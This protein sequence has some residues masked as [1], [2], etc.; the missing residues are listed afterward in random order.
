[1]NETLS[2]IF[3]VNRFDGFH[4]FG[5]DRERTIGSEQG[6]LALGSSLK[7]KKKLTSFLLLEKAE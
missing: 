3:L 6:Q 1:L 2:K 7:K 5:F 4:R